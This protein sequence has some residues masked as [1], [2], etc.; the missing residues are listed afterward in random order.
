MNSSD[1]TTLITNTIQDLPSFDDGGTD[2][3]LFD[4]IVEM[5]ALALTQ[6]NPQFDRQSFEA[7]CYNTSKQVA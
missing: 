2:V 7:D 6:I 3:V 5:F 1:L 4:S